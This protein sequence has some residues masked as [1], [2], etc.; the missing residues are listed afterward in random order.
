MH[1]ALLI[2][3]CIFQACLRVVKFI[4]TYRSNILLSLDGKNEEA[5]LSDLG[6][7]IHRTIYEH[8][9]QYQFNL[10][11][12]YIFVRLVGMVVILIHL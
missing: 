10:V 1:R 6:V 12:A 8:F 4:N 7:K 2:L 5:V 11:G 9:Q 3:R